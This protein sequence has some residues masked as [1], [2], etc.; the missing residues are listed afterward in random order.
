VGELMAAGLPSLLIPDP[1]HS[2]KQQLANAR[3]LERAGLGTIID[4]DSARGTD[5]L[6]WLAQVWDMGRRP[7]GEPPAAAIGEDIL[8][9]A[10]SA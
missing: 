4:Q 6:K 7:E 5:V 1:Q 3:E 8:R 2:D 10:V 9:V